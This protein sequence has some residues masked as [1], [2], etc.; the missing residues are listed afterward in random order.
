M[1]E[2]LRVLL[3]SKEESEQE[4]TVFLADMGDQKPRR[5]GFFERTL[6]TQYGHIPD[7]KV[8]KLPHSNE[9]RQWKILERYQRCLSNLFN[10]ICCLYVM[11]LSLSRFTGSIISPFGSCFV[12]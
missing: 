10:W 1:G 3:T 12:P 8:P 7:L 5:S 4:V 6:D 9:H 11:G 2:R